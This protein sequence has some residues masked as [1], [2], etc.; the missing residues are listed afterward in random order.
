MKYTKHVV[1]QGS[2]DHVI[3]IVGTS[4]KEGFLVCSVE[5]CEVNKEWDRYNNNKK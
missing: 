4:N 1:K 2:R 3:S 5:N